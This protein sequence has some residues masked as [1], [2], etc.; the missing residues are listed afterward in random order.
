MH[1]TNVGIR[2]LKNRLSHY[3]LRIKAGETLVITEHGK[4]IGQIV[5]IQ[6]DRSDHLHR[7]AE[8]GLV[9]WNGQ[10][11][12]DYQPKAINRSKHLLSDLVSEER[13]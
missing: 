2:E 11:L 8:A 9:D 4:P 12:P 13:E 3:L 6:A 5:P 1:T 10:K 7:L